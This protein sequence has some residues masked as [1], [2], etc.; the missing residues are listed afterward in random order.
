MCVHTCHVSV[1]AVG[2]KGKVSLVHSL[3]SLKLIKK[4]RL[5]NWMELKKYWIVDW[6]IRILI[7]TW[8]GPIQPKKKV[9]KKFKEIK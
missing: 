2:N 8:R 9:N 3:D 6:L 4:I 5:R 1:A 7:F